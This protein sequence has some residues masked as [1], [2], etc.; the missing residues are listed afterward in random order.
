MTSATHHPRAFPLSG[1]AAA[2]DQPLSQGPL[3]GLDG[4]LGAIPAKVN[5]LPVEEGIGSS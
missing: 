3:E 1:Q 2:V 5:E 4:L